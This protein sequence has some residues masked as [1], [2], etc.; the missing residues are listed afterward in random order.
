MDLVIGMGNRWRGDDGVGCVVIEAVPCRPGVET[1]AV[2]QL[3]PELAERIQA[4][5]RVLFVDASTDVQEV[6]LQRIEPSPQRGLGHACSPGGLL[7]W[8]AQAYG[9]APEAWLL[10]VPAATFDLGAGLSPGVARR[11]PGTVAAV[12]AWLDR[13]SC[14]VQMKNEEE[15]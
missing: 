4:A 5:H 10:E 1:V 3:V 9:A 2:H 8:T 6:T 15:A 13:G 11:V 12:T 14:A 7:A